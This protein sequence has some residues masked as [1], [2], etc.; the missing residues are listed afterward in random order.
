[1]K[2]VIKLCIFNVYNGDKKTFNNASTLN[3]IC[4]AYEQIDPPTPNTNS[5]H[6]FVNS[7]HC[8][9]GCMDI[10]PLVGTKSKVIEM[11]ADISSDKI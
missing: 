3:N 1:M 7:N 9:V 5:K 6:C 2:D 10:N 4:E 11:V 8:L